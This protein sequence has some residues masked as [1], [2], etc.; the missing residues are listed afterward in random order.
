MAR[1]PKTPTLPA[2]PSEKMPEPHGVHVVLIRP[3]ETRQLGPFP[4]YEQAMSMA[5][6]AASGGFVA[7]DTA[8]SAA[9]VFSARVVTL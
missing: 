8:Y 9:A 5:K 2:P 4:D 7:G 3:G 1:S 6:R